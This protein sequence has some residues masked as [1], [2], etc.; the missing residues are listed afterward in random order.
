MGP[1][2]MFGLGANGSFEEWI[3]P[4]PLPPHSITSSSFQF[5]APR[6]SRPHVSARILPLS[7]TSYARTFPEVSLAGRERPRAQAISTSSHST[8][9]ES[10]AA[11]R[12]RIEV[13]FLSILELK[14]TQ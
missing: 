11:R 5:G 8:S 13:G 14:K 3:P 9:A 12:K 7:G 2:P 4:P 1:F 6:A 10:E